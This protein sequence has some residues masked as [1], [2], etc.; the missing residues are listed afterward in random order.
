MNQKFTTTELPRTPIAFFWYV[1]RK[2]KW[3]A[4]LATMFVILASSSG[5][6]IRF[7]IEFLVGAIERNEIND[8]VFWG[9]MYP[10]LF[11]RVQ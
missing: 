1:S 10:V 4:L 7:L 9:L 5:V 6:A 2:Y 3:W 11:L 8:V